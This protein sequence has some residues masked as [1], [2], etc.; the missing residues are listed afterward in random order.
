MNTHA[1]T[2]TL[3]Q[4]HANRGCL[5]IEFVHEF[6]RGDAS[7]APIFTPNQKRSLAIE[8]EKRRQPGQSCNSGVTLVSRNNSCSEL[9]NNSL[10]PH[11]PDSS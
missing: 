3:M 5:G 10:Q 4:S 2:K 1:K 9:I 6:G 7:K 11:K 8:G